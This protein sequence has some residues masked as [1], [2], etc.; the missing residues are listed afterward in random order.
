MREHDFKQALENFLNPIVEKMVQQVLIEKNTDST[1]IKEPEQF[2]T[3]GK[4]AKE[5]GCTTHLL[6]KAMNN[7]ELEY[8]HAD[9][10]TYVRRKHV[11]NYLESI[12]IPSKESGE[13]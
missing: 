4:A 10:R 5:F 1:S 13:L 2:L 3:V 9:N 7:Q 12:K 8:Y 6:Q 11:F